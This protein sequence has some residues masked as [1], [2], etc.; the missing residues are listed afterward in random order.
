MNEENLKLFLKNGVT[1]SFNFLFFCIF[2]FADFSRNNNEYL[3]RYLSG[4][5]WS[6][7]PS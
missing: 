1:F 2:S 6:K 3:L 4:G 7:G 5:F